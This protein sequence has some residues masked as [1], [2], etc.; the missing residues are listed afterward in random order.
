[1]KLLIKWKGT[2]LQACDAINRTQDLKE[3]EEQTG[4]D[5]KL[6]LFGPVVFLHFLVS[7]VFL[8]RL[9]LSSS[10]LNDTR[11]SLFFSH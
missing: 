10:L 4:G 5:G 9:T 7:M 1:V 11:L 8:L 3:E 6:S 2:C